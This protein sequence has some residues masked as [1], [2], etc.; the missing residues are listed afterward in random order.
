MLYDAE[1]NILS[2]EI[3]KGAISHAVELGNF[4]IHVSPAGTPVLIEIINASKFVG[5]FNKIKLSKLENVKQILPA[6]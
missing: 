6:G 5:Q 2:W 3:A 4:I 1:N